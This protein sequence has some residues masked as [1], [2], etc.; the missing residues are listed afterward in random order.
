MSSITSHWK[1]DLHVHSA[2]SA[3]PYSWF[4]RSSR[5][6]ECYTPVDRVYD[7]AKRRGMDLVTLADHDTIDGSLELCARH[8]GDTFVSVEVSARFPEDGC[9]IHLIA[10][11]IDERQHREMQALRK[12][13]YEL[14]G[15]LHREQIGNFWCH[16][17]SQVNGRLT[18]E[19]LERGLL[20]FRALEVRNGTRDVAHERGLLEVMS[21]LTPATLESWADRH[22]HAP[23]LNRDGRYAL[24][25]GS[26]D[27]GSLAIARAY[28]SFRGEKSGAGVAA[29]LRLGVTAPGGDAGTGTT[30]AHNCYGV[31]AGYLH[32]HGQRDLGGV[33]PGPSSP[34]PARAKHGAAQPAVSSSILT[35]LVDAQ[36]TTKQP[37]PMVEALWNTGHLTPQ[38]ELMRA[39]AE[40]ALSGSWRKALGGVIEPVK[41][42]QIGVAADGVPALLRTLALELPYLLAHRYHVRDRR[43]AD[44]FATELGACQ[45]G[46]ARPKVAV[47][48]DTIDHVNGVAIGLR[49]L[50]AEAQRDGVD[51]KLVG[52][53]KVPKL[54]IDDDGIYRLPSVYEHHLAEYP[55]MAWSVPH[56]P[57]LLRFLEEEDIDLIQCSTPGPVGLAA[58]AA[59]RLAGLPVI[60]QYHTDV[61]EYALRLTGDPA[62]AA[63]VR[64]LVAWFY[65]GV[66]RVLVP[67]D[68]VG[69]VVRGLGVPTEH[70][71]RI[72][73]GIDLAQFSPE[74]RDPGAMAA[75]GLGDGPVVLYV[76]RLSREK[77]IDQVLAAFA[78]VQAELPAA[79]LLLVG[80]GPL[81]ADLER[82]APPGCMLTGLVTGA[83]LATLYASAD[84]FMFPSETETFGN[85]VVEAQASGLPVIV[86]DRGATREH[87]VDG[88]TGFALDP[89]DTLAT[90]RAML[91]ILRD[92][93]LR[94]RM[95]RAAAQHATRYDMGDALRGTYRCYG[96]IVEELRVRPRLDAARSAVRDRGMGGMVA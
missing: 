60:G 95:S 5:A 59:G 64:Q 90:S 29:A 58:M 52:C 15:Y 57:P 37:G 7:T 56:L 81:R 26:D 13:V 35:A 88:V 77:S 33:T 86:S 82:N 32:S 87:V 70:L 61:P 4:L 21:R 93:D 30:L 67:S 16:P 63:L 43:G 66:D 25:G 84:L 51:L 73:R 18:R 50:L 46:K 45:L 6:A 12:D 14:V 72:P 62:A 39:A 48:T 1:V 2:H 65:R 22:P 11:D 54:T 19:H 36:D 78:A 24:V 55:E 89:R 9:I 49:R 27:H 20:M 28:T 71:V 31:L 91:R 23:F 44:R 69:E 83:P 10:V 3:S 80:D 92:G 68:W 76:G 8:P 74:H 41:Q 34:L 42:G 38:Q 94:A 75:L 47:F 85:V 40:L 53:A 96:R 17:L 79:R